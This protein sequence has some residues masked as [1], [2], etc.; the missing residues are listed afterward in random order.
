[1][2]LLFTSWFRYT[3]VLVS[4]PTILKLYM[5]LYG[6]SIQ[7]LICGGISMVPLKTLSH[8]ITIITF[9][10][11]LTTIIYE[12]G[13]HIVS[14]VAFLALGIMTGINY[15]KRHRTLFL[16]LQV[17]FFYLLLAESAF[18]IIFRGR[19]LVIMIAT[20]IPLLIASFYTLMSERAKLKIIYELFSTKKS[21][22]P[23]HGLSRGPG[24][25]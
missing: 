11:A 2:R 21:S 18:W 12:R 16:G 9:L 3:H 7:I 13:S 25:R 20:V 8:A 5:F 1:V 15:A 17:L 19:S 4:T 6:G 23:P 10:L 24:V 14:L 22:Q